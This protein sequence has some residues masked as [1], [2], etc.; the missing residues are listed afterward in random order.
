M[1]A[2]IVALMVP[3]QSVVATSHATSGVT[4]SAVVFNP[5]NYTSCEFGIFGGPVANFGDPLPPLEH[6]W[7]LL[8]RGSGPQS[9]DLRV[10]THAVNVVEEG[11][12]VTFT[13]TDPAGPTFIGD[14]TVSQPATVGDN[15]DILSLTLTG[16]TVYDLKVTLNAPSSTT[17]RTARHYKIG[18]VQPSVEL[19][20]EGNGLHYFES[21]NVLQ[22]NADVSPVAVVVSADDPTG[23]GEVPPQATTTDYTVIDSFGTVVTAMTAASISPGSPATIGFSRTVGFVDPYTLMTLAN[24]HTS[25]VKTTGS[26]TG[27]YVKECN[28]QPQ[29]FHITLSPDFAVNDVGTDHT[30][31]ATVTGTAGPGFPINVPAPGVLVDFEVIGGP[32]TGVSGTCSING[33]CTTDVNGQVSWTYTGSG[34]V[35]FDTIEAGFD[36][37]TQFPQIVNHVIKEW[38]DPQPPSADARTIGFWKNHPDLIGE[39]IAEKKIGPAPGLTVPEILAILKNASAK[40][41]KNALRA[42]RMAAILNLRNGADRNATGID[43]RDVIDDAVP[44]L[45]HAGKL[46]NKHKDVHRGDALELKDLLDEFN[47]SGE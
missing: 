19:G 24:G 5:S 14:R 7:K 44:L 1:L 4:F 30:V 42:Q 12:S 18:A 31:T 22:I 33:D 16:G 2:G 10:V 9:V 45:Q 29:P 13:V 46:D 37:G 32:N 15:V 27:F 39:F 38:V 8:A 28:A 23:P 41:A 17:L 40:D 6:N 3:V 25:A 26:D 35:G 20:I 34:G 47:N 11:G 36:D 43:I 21:G